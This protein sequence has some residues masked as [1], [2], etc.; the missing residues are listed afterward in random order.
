[1]R[2]AGSASILD[3][4]KVASIGPITTETARRLG[5]QVTAQAR[6]FTRDG[7]LEA[8]VAAVVHSADAK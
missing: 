2:A 3:G 8:L 4:V 5:I 7:L 6:E 1:M